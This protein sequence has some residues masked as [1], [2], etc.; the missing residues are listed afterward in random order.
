MHLRPVRNNRLF[1]Y[2]EIFKMTYGFKTIIEFEHV[3]ELVVCS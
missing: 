3:K 2:T 1:R